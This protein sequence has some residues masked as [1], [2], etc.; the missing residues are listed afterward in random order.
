MPGL[1]YSRPG[2]KSLTNVGLLALYLW[3]YLRGMTAYLLIAKLEAYGL[4]TV[5]L[6]LLK[7]YL[8]NREQRTKAGSSYRVQILT[9][10]SQRLYIRSTTF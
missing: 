1:D 7:N 2:K 3:I 8:A 6:S 4:D 5:S 10:N 9:R